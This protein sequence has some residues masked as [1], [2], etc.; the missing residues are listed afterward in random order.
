VKDK[1]I[2]RRVI[3]AIG[4]ISGSFSSNEAAAS[5]NAVLAKWD[6]YYDAHPNRFARNKRYNTLSYF[7][8]AD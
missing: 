4:Q 7:M 2:L 1:T 5:H 8:S 3:D 6:Q